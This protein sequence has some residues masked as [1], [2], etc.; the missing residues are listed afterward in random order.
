MLF[1]L[2]SSERSKGV[3]L[4]SMIVCALVIA[5]VEDGE[6]FLE[7]LVSVI[8]RCVSGDGGAGMLAI[9]GLVVAGLFLIL[10]RWGFLDELSQRAQSREGKIA[11][12][13]DGQP[14]DLEQGS[15]NRLDVY[16]GF[17]DRLSEEDEEA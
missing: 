13:K 3:R 7:D 4:F 12:F 15:V 9:V 6:T 5:L 11:R 2:C 16:R 14:N 1:G 10:W 17:L 8:P